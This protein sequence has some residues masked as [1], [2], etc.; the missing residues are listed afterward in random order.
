[1]GQKCT[2]IY[3]CGSCSATCAFECVYCITSANW[4]HRQCQ[5]MSDKELR[6]WGQLELDYV[7]TTCRSLN[8]SMFDFVSA[9]QRL[10]MVNL[11]KLTAAVDRELLFKPRL[12]IPV[13]QHTDFPIADSNAAYI[14]ANYV[15][16]VYGNP[17]TNTGDGNC[18]YNAISILLHGNESLATQ[19]RYLTCIQLVKNMGAYMNHPL[20]MKHVLMQI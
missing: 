1:M 15:D 6:Q 13:K 3:P 18:L 11:A 10:G 17:I 16:D 2:K 4:Y 7:C 14:M 8:G 5:S 12:S 19:L 20:S 9:L